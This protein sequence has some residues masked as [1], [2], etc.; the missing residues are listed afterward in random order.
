MPEIGPTDVLIRVEKAGVCG[1]DAH[2]YGWDAW[3]QNRIKPPLVVGHEFMGI[4]ERVGDAVHRVAVG[5]R[6]SAEGHIADLTC[7]L[8]RTGNAHIC[9][10]VKIIGVDRDGAF[11]QYIAMP[12][13]NVWKLD[14][15]IA[16]EVAAIFDPLG[17]AVHTVMAA[18][19]SVKSVAIT[20]VGSIGLMAIPVARAAGASFGLRDRRESGEARNGEETWRRRDLRRN[21][22]RLGRR[23]QGT[24][25]R[26]RRRRAARDVGQRRG[27]RSRTAT[28]AQRRNGGDARHSR[29]IT[30]T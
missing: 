9:E 10:R 20:G 3:A 5:D 26:R 30:S 18:G 29:P 2:I 23:D 27:D 16:D 13:Y 28:R 17:N 1:T 21:A 15:A 6:V 19:V 4:V 25:A 14:P 8:C 12:E 22:E 11:A 24:N 7:L